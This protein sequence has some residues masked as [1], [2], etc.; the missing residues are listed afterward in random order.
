ML[1]D[2][3]QSGELD[4]KL[5]SNRH[6]LVE[7][8]FEGHPATSTAEI[9]IRK[10]INRKY[11]KNPVPK[12]FDYKLT[13][14]NIL[15]NPSSKLE[16]ARGSLGSSDLD[17]LQKIQYAHDASARLKNPEHTGDRILEK[18]QIWDQQNNNED[19][20]YSYEDERNQMLRSRSYNLQKSNL[21]KTPLRSNIDYQYIDYGLYSDSKGADQ[22]P[23]IEPKPV[24]NRNIQSKRGEVAYSEEEDYT[25]WSDYHEDLTSDDNQSKSLVNSFFVFQ[26]LL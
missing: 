10:L 9:V 22:R 8:K 12:N 26:S 20:D 3:G 7:V 17:Y 25:Y 5:F 2:G 23:V 19:D 15:K 21:R 13:P 6:F 11:P 16:Q 1:G 24:P 4:D 14:N 18:N